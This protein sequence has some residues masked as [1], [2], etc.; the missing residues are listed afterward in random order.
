MDEI[1][2]RLFHWTAYHQGIGTEVSSYLHTGNA[3][4]LIDPMLPPGGIAAVEELGRPQTI[5]LTNRHHLRH[6]ERFVAEL[7][8]PIR[9]HEAGLHE[10]ADGRES[11]EGFS[12]GDELAPG[13]EALEV[14]VICPEETALHIAAGHGALAFADGIIHY[15]GTIG[16]VPDPLLGDDP[17]AIKRGLRESIGELLDHEFDAVLFAHG[18]PITSGGREALRRFLEDV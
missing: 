12:F 4:T 7:G 14:G 10:F 15:R 3:V 18:D 11:V 5:V 13:I 2:P 16:F 9:C 17:E 1:L 6:S 8:C